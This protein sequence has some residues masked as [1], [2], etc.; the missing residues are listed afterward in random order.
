V[1]RAT[2]AAFA[3]LAL[4]CVALFLMV[5]FEK[6]PPKKTS[7]ANEAASAASHSGS[8][9]TAAPSPTKTQAS[10]DPA[11]AIELANDPQIAAHD[12][13]E[14]GLPRPLPPTVSSKPLYPPKAEGE[15]ARPRGSL[16]KDQ[17][18]SAIRTALPAI[19]SCYEKQLSRNPKLA[20]RTTVSMTIR[21][22]DGKGKLVDADILPGSSDEDL[23][24]PLTEQCI[25]GALTAV[26]FP[27]PKGGDVV[28][29]YP[30]KL[31]AGPPP[32]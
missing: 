2:R 10:A 19:A 15:P 5:A 9:P 22:K 6:S 18:M 32:R 14:H 20:G 17:V 1:K 23:N 12:T 27:A 16:D 29:H 7:S 3:F 11:V 31:V 25:L 30:F 13:L 4:V 28:I 26:D 24:S 8:Q 21:E